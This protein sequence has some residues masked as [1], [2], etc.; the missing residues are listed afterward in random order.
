[1][2]NINQIGVIG[3][4]TR[5]KVIKEFYGTLDEKIGG[6]SYYCGL[7]LANLGVPAVVFNKVGKDDLDLLDSLRHRNIELVNFISD[8][9]PVF[10]NVFV[11]RDLEER[12][13]RATNDSFV[14]DVEALRE[15]ISKFS[16][17]RYIHLAPGKN[18]E[19]PL[20]SVE[21]LKKNL[22]AKLSLDVE[23]LVLENIDGVLQPF[24]N[25]ELPEILKNIDILQVS[26]KFL[27]VL[28]DN[29][30]LKK[31]D[32]LCDM[33]KS[34]SKTGLSIVI[35]TRGS[36][37]SLIYSMGKLCIVESCKAE[38]ILD[39]TGAG[40]THIACFL[41]GMMIH[42]GD[43]KLAGDHAAYLTAKKIENGGPL[44]A[45]DSSSFSRKMT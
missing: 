26:E 28:A 30:S 34:I 22:D 32:S 12:E 7:A 5:D 41:H 45:G 15:N 43:V 35:I 39:T 33:A 24:I 42:G 20:S 11:D 10:E 14:Y 18:N 17:C 44:S 25:H 6:K 16:G 3:Y 13:Y 8:R 9:T 37:G 19:I 4:I 23:H 36:K 1:M 27:S 31:N 29:L 21:Y 2:V 38:K 40:D